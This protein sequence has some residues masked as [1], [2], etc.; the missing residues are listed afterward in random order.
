MVKHG[1]TIIVDTLLKI[2]NEIFNGATA[3]GIWYS[4]II[5]PIPKKKSKTIELA[6][7][8]PISLTCIPAK[9][10]ESI[11]SQRLLQV[12]DTENWL[13]VYQ[14]GFRKK[15]STIDNLIVLQQEIHTAFQKKEVL[16]AAFL[17]IKKAYDS[18]DRKILHD[19]F[20]E[21]RVNGKLK[22]WIQNFL[23]HKREGVVRFKNCI[24]K[25]YIFR[26][27]VPQGSPISPL[28]FNIYVSGLKE[29]RPKKISQFADDIV[30]WEK[31]QDFPKAERKLNDSLEKINVWAKTLALEFSQT[32]SLVIPFT[33]KHI[34]ATPLIKLDGLEINVSDSAKYLGVTFD[35]NLCWTAHVTEI[36]KTARKRMFLLKRMSNRKNGLNQT[37]LLKLYTY[38]IRPIL[39]YGAVVWGDISK[40]NQD[41]LNSVQ[42]S[43][44]TTALGVMRI[45]KRKHVNFEGQI[46]PLNLR[47]EQQ[48][49]RK[50]RDMKGNST[51]DFLCNM[52]SEK[53][54]I[55]SF[56]K[57][58]IERVVELSKELNLCLAEM[59]SLK[60]SEIEAIFQRKFIASADAYEQDYFNLKRPKLAYV[61]FG[62]TRNESS[63]WHQARLNMLPLNNILHRIKRAENE[64]C[65]AC[66][67]SETTMHFIFECPMYKEIWEKNPKLLEI[68]KNRPKEILCLKKSDAHKR[69]VSKI[70]FF[71]AKRRKLN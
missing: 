38:T 23:L 41:A 17:D 52:P 31:S 35:K 13:P 47:R 27:G 36:I 15:M 1:G 7:F 8:R 40:K 19:R 22:K 25:K 59:W 34:K 24:S 54:L 20:D 60:N 42:Q 45:S 28:L 2:F 5:V 64:N 44:I 9:L 32:K 69:K 51:Y 70:L 65:T 14:N 66:N 56:R 6:E 11:M 62:A 16:L 55:N 58:F 43:A 39:E 12:S 33:R 49:I 50:W 63:V 67:C 46:W 57:S 10:F 21:L 48:L 71:S 29:L 61:S 53:R 30:I 3:P 4:S 68:R 26:N 18:V 37:I